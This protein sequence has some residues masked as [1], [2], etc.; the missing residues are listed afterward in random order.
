MYFRATL[1][2]VFPMPDT[3][4]P[5]RN[6]STLP[7]LLAAPRLSRVTS[8]ESPVTKSSRINTYKSLS[9]QRTLTIF[10][11]I[12]LQETRGGVM[13][14]Q[15]SAQVFSKSPG[16]DPFLSFESPATSPSHWSRRSLVQQWPPAQEFF[17]NPGKQLRSTRCLREVS[18]H[19]LRQQLDAVPVCKSCLGLPF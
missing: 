4:P 14:N 3:S 17:A 18:G 11:M 1:S 10:R 13:A 16:W 19:R 9:K 12:Y 6:P 2:S 15:L 5:R 7:A 8:H